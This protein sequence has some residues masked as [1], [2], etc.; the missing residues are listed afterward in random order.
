MNK[1]EERV[2]DIIKNIEYYSPV[3]FIGNSVLDFKKIYNKRV[4]RVTDAESV[5]DIVS[6]YMNIDNLD[7]PLVVDGLSFLEEKSMF[8]LLKLV[9]ESSFPIILLSRF[10]KVSPIILSR[11]KT[12]IKYQTEK[13]NSEFLDCSDGE[14]IVK[15]KLSEESSYFDRLKYI[16]KFSPKMYY[17]EKQLNNVRNKE[18][19]KSIL[20]S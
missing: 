13:V 17:Y 12:I 20:Y 9:E 2:K 10:D 8:L 3:I 15:E 6:Y 1:N 5:R 19:I 4:I 14:E 16:S 7:V 18:K 11:I